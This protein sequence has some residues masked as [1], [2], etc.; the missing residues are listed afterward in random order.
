MKV[1]LLDHQSV[2]QSVSVFPPVITLNLLVDSHE[3][4]YGGNAIQGDLGAVIVNSIA[5]II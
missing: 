5:S 2:C 3:I 4:W 1:G